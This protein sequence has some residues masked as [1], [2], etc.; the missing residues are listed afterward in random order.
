MSSST[1]DTLVNKKCVPCHGG[2]SALTPAEAQSMLG[3]LL[4]AAG[5]SPRTARRSS[6]SSSFRIS[7]A[8]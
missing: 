4:G 5:N 7:T 6:A 8:R 3:R 2:V 1:D